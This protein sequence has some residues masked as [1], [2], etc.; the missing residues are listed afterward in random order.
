MS[1]RVVLFANGPVGARAAQL[2]AADVGSEV[3][4]VVVHPEARARSR[5]EIVRAAGIGPERIFEGQNLQDERIL[6]D[7]AALEPALGLSVYFGHILRAP[8]LGLFPRGVVNLHP[9][10]LPYNRGSYPNVWSIVDGTPAGATLHYID[11]GIDTGDIIAQRRVEVSPSDTGG[12]LYAKLEEGAVELL[13]ETWPTIVAGTNRRTP[14]LP[15]GTVHRM[16]DVETIDPIDLDGVVTA[17]RLIDI[18]RARTFAPH[19]GAYFV[20]DGVRVYLRLEL[21]P[22]E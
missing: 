16:R 22:E 4:A 6:A 10:L 2:V 13:G 11:E 20:V 14:Q 19:R 3:V 9:S 7:I 15:G 12:T 1:L 8:L 18:L 5:D 21:T 17:R